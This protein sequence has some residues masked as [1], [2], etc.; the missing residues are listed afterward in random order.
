MACFGQPHQPVDVLEVGRHRRVAPASAAAACW[1]RTRSSA[2]PPPASGTTRRRRVGEAE[3]L[4][5]GGSPTSAP[6]RDWA[7]A[8]RRR[9]CAA[10]SRG[11]RGDGLVLD[12]Q[13]VVGLPGDAGRRPVGAAGEDRLRRAVRREVDH[14]LVVADMGGVVEHPVLDV[15]AGVARGACARGRVADRPS[16][17]R[18]RPCRCWR[19]SRGC[20]RRWRGAGPRA[21]VSSSS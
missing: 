15:D 13:R 16:A 5:P 10:S 9:T 14:E 4:R 2:S 21:R 12:E 19:G 3:R 1:A 20:G 7:P 6:K 11:R 18:R 8:A 17:P